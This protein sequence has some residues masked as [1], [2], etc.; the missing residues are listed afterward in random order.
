MS[1][2]DAIPILNSLKG[3]GIL[4]KDLKSDWVGG[5][6]YHGVEY[7]TGPS[8]VDAHLV[9]EVSTRVNPIW[10]TMGVIPGMI[11]DEVVIFGNHR[12]AWVLGAS[13]PNSG[14]ATQHELIRG[15]GRLLSQGWKP[16]RTIVLASWDAEEYGLVGSTEWTEDFGDWLKANAAVYLNLDSSTSGGSILG[17]AASPSLAWTLRNAAAE[18][19]DTNS[20]VSVL[21]SQSRLETWAEWRTEKYGLSGDEDIES[22]FASETKV[23][24]LG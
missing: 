8:Q 6:E 23:A 7:W 17:M 1:Y 20:S 24:P 13:D 19:L 9:N 21:D 11:Q 5:L 10:N 3:Q 14:T 15:L 18:V 22:M 12:D 2:E 16:T 4:A